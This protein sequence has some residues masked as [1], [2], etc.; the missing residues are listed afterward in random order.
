MLIEEVEL[1]IIF[2]WYSYFLDLGNGRQTSITT[3][4]CPRDGINSHYW[5]YDPNDCWCSW[6]PKARAESAIT[7]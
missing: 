5:F 4:V 1:L 2:P 3:M 6:L 7:Q